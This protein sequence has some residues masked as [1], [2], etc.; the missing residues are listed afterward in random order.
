[1]QLSL[2]YPLFLRQPQR[3]NQDIQYYNIL[4]EIRLG[5]IYINIW[6]YLYQKV[7]EFNHQNALN[8]INIVRY[9][10]TTNRINN[11]ICN[12]LPVN[13]DKFIISTAIDFINGERYNPNDSQK[14][15]KKKTNLPSYLRL[16]QGARIMYLKNNLIEQNI[17]NSTIGIVTDINLESLQVRIAFSIMGEI[18]NIQIKKETATFTIDRKP[19]SRYQFP[20]QNAFAFTVYKT[21]GLTLPEISLC[22][23]QQIFSASQVY[24]ALS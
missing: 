11:I 20:L 8:I 7:R 9:K 21:Q 18:I 3:Q 12:M 6:N 24:V 13:E 14:L 2:F 23:D 19:S 15:F 10:Q 22:L 16:Q 1:M 5:N 4:Q 17:C